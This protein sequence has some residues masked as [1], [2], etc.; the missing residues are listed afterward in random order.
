MNRRK[1][2]LLKRSLIAS[3][4]AV[5]FVGVG[6]YFFQEESEPVDKV[7]ASDVVGPPGDFRLTA[8]NRWDNS[9]DVKKNYADLDWDP[10]DNLTQAGYRLFQSED[11]ENWEN[12]SILYGKSI[13]VL[14]V[15]PDISE[16]NTLKNW[17]DS[18]NLQAT[19][20]TNLIQVT[21]LSINEYNNDPDHYLQNSSGEYL[22]DVIMFG[23]WDGNNSR[24]ISTQSAEATIRF[25][26]SGRGVL[27]GHDTLLKSQSVWWNYFHDLSNYLGI[28]HES[29]MESG[30]GVA[31]EYWSISEKV[32]II[33]DG[34]L[35]KY[36]IELQNELV[37]T[38]PQTHNVELS[39]KSIGTVWMEFEDAIN[40]I[41]DEGGKWRGGWYLK[42]NKNIAMIQTGHSSGQ[43]TL[44][45]RK[46][47]ANVLYN[48]GQVSLE[49]N[50]SDHSVKDKVAP[51]T[52][53][54]IIRC[55]S[56]EGLNIKLD[57]VDRGTDY[58]FYVEANTQGGRLTSDVVKEEIKSNIA[59]YFYEV[60]DSAQSTLTSTVEGYKNEYGRI[61][62]ARYP[63]GL[64]VAPTDPED[65]S[66]QYET[67]TT[68]SLSEKNTSGKY[69]HVVAVDRANNIS[70]VSSQ[71]IDQ[72][73]QLI[74]FEI[75]RTGD[76]AKFVDLV[77]DNSIN[78][79]MK[80]IEIQVPKN[81]EIKG[82]SDSLTLPNT[83]Y[84]FENSETDDY[85][86]FS[87]AME[88]NNSVATIQDFM[89]DLRFTI[90]NPVNTSGSIKVILHEK[91]YTSW[92]DENE[93][94][95]YY[96]FMPEM[97]APGKT[98]F[99]AYNSAKQ[100]RYK[101][102]TG[103][104]TT[105]TS[106][107]EHDFIFNNIA[108]DPGWLGG[109]RGVLKNGD[110]ISDNDKIPAVTEEYD[111]TKDNWYW[112]NGPETGEIFFVGKR[113]IDG[114][115]APDG[116]YAAFN[117][118]E[119][120][121]DRVTGPEFVLQFA[122]KNSK[123]WNDLPGGTMYD[124]LY[125]RG[126]YVEFSQYG[127][128]EEKEEITDVCWKAAIPQKVSLKAYDDRGTALAQGDILYDQ[129]LRI[130]NKITVQEKELELY[131]FIKAVDM[132]DVEKTS[133]TVSKTYQEG[134][135]IY[136][137]RRADLHVRQVIQNP[138]G[139]LVVPKEGYL[140]I[141]NQLHTTGALD[142]NYQVNTAVTS[143]KEA[144]DPDF[145]T[146]VVSTSQLTNDNDEVQLSAVIPEF[147]KYNG[148]RISNDLAS[149]AAAP[150]VT[151]AKISLSCLGIYNQREHWITI[152][153]EPNGTN[154]GKPQPYSWDYKKN[155]LGK[156]KTK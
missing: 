43:S 116:A 28:G 74:D 83:W 114:A 101:G 41:Y 72:L 45:E 69:L 52:P 126:Y 53:E 135:L 14:N 144:D 119:P 124:Q 107:E 62:V 115:Y 82:Y 23:T 61:P 15:Y 87:F 103:Y 46:I 55:G 138:N 8:E 42:T 30:G 16:S 139:E 60:T 94:A 80:S 121:N 58:Q 36:P 38:V 155:D 10:Q 29:Y 153:L 78:N 6:Y 90:K 73:T 142:T 123:Y 17:M 49:N 100:L 51:N 32:K 77:I 57:A 105:I 148:Y 19:D 146:V 149:H 143:G 156:I 27:L 2:K 152:Y 40:S 125:N 130:G 108:K 56:D 4:V 59:G 151:D 71:Q 95:H 25:L 75:E 64:Y 99:Q 88:N 7:E 150:L 93:V 85:Y 50:A 31:W 127:N 154:D 24:D 120:N 11:G 70:E 113:R 145:T 118:E 89:E 141:Q 9:T 63:E 21:P 137:I 35:M 76:E 22:Y 26:S 20:G 106:E 98:W 110:N 129:Q 18:L 54:T 109:T 13:R 96:V 128:Q 34:Y 44:D 37:L 79:K 136:S 3:I 104:L 147:Y 81:T 91:V 5:I 111:V 117:A 68:I 133:Y 140:T 48:L 1:K 33:N 12:R 67:A 132:S 86:S 65:H 97:T 131:S 134:K 112:A 84:S 122:H 47:I 39:D 66:L 92:I 102:L